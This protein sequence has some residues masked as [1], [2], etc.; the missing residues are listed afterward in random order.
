MSKKFMQIIITA[1][2]LVVLAILLINNLKG[3]SREKLRKVQESIKEVGDLS[4]SLA[5]LSVDE[6]MIK[7]QK[8]RAKT[9][10]W[11]RDPF[12]YIEVDRDKSYRTDALVLGGISL[13][14]DKPGFAFINNEIVKTG[15][16]IGG[17]EVVRIQKDK[18]LLKRGSQVFYLTMPEE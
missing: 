11:G 10:A 5:I 13:G 8:E 14:R 16:T 18:V 1:V 2:L 17:Y 6:T 15:D 12:Q 9:L 4:S 3:G 7:S